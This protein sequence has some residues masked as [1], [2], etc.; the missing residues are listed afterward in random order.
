M[1]YY[2][3]KMNRLID[4]LIPKRR[5][6]NAAWLHWRSADNTTVLWV[7]FAHPSYGVPRS[8]G[9]AVV[10][11]PLFRAQMVDINGVVTPLEALETFHQ[12]FQ[13]QS[14]IM[15]WELAGEL[16]DHHGSTIRIDGTNGI[17]SVTLQVP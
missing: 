9:A 4:S 1:Y 16:K 6:K 13:S 7:R 15:G 14:L 10:P 11:P 5:D 3:G 8:R 2:G 12:E 17:G